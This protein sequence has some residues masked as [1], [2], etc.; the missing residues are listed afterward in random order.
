VIGIKG[1]IMKDH[2]K[3]V[4]LL[5]LSIHTTVIAS[6]TKSYPV[7][8]S[9]KKSKDCFGANGM[10]IRKAMNVIQRQWQ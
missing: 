8:P 7:I 10:A 6:T 2:R 9:T 3:E 5:C 4:E 1:E